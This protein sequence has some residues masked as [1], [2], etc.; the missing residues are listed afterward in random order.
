MIH[1]NASHARDYRGLNSSSI[2]RAHG[3]HVS[4]GRARLVLVV[5]GVTFTGK[6]DRPGFSA[7]A[8]TCN[9]KWVSLRASGC[10]CVF[11]RL[12]RRIHTRG[13][14]VRGSRSG[15]QIAGSVREKF[16]VHLQY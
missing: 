13:A 1:D 5:F 9:C 10:V 12:D 15:L 8:R 4:I 11:A 6:N 2:C 14:R 16:R 7:R 3:R